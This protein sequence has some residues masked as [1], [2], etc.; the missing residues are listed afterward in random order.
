MIERFASCAKSTVS[1][2]DE[3]CEREA[4]AQLRQQLQEL[5]EGSSER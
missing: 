1:L 5:L 2:E 4:C 3:T